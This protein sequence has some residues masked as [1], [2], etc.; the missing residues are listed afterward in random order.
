[1]KFRYILV[2]CLFIFSIQFFLQ[3]SWYEYVI[4]MCF[5]LLE[6][7]INICDSISSSHAHAHT[8]TQ[9]HTER[10]S[11]CECRSMHSFYEAAMKGSSEIM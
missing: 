9:T 10:D 6:F 2:Q 3:Q 4:C 11:V 5:I 8:H 1:M 7:Y